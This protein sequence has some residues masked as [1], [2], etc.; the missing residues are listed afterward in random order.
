MVILSIFKI[1]FFEKLA[2]SHSIL[3][4]YPHVMHLSK[5]KLGLSEFSE[6]YLSEIACPDLTV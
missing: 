4:E 6:T 5:F 1:A 2:I 3:L